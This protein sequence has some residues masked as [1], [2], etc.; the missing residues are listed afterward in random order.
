MLGRGPPRPGFKIIRHG[1]IGVVGQHDLAN[2]QPRRPRPQTRERIAKVAA[3]HNE[4]RRLAV[5]APYPKA[6]RR[7]VRHLRQQAPK[8]D[9]V[10]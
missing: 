7:K 10:G 2:G 5:A 1:A 8:V 9:A 4:R 3:R 6:R